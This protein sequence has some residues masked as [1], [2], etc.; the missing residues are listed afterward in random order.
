MII[1][2]S[3]I[4]AVIFLE[5]A[6]EQIVSVLENAESAAIGSATLFETELVLC[7]RR[8]PA[9]RAMAMTF[10]AEFGLDEIT[11]DE[12]HRSAATS[13]F[14]RFGKGRHPARL[15][16]A[17]CMTYATARIAGEPLLC[18]GDDFAKTDIDLVLPP[19]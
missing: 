11:F 16:L 17:D 9:G 5:R 12:R 10:V 18:V 13:A 19:G 1:D 15:N 3:A 4:V 14:I 8:G 2:S 7:A 6:H